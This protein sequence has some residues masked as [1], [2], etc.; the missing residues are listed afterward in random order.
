MITWYHNFTWIMMIKCSIAENLQLCE[1][2]ISIWPADQMMSHNY[3]PSDWV[4]NWSL[5]SIKRYPNGDLNHW[6]CRNVTYFAAGERWYTHSCPLWPFGRR[7]GVAFSLP[8]NQ[9]SNLYEIKIIYRYHVAKHSYHWL[10]REI[11][12]GSEICFWTSII[13]LVQNQIW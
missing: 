3:V 1:K 7:F 4:I 2:S 5:S 8:I 12:W 13:S 6:N 10:W 11:L 9:S